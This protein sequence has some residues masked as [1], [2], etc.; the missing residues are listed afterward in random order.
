MTQEQ[1]D[2]FMHYSNLNIQATWQNIEATR[3]AIKYSE[4]KDLPKMAQAMRQQRESSEKA[5]M[6]L[7]EM[8]KCK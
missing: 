6:Y 5:E 8:K 1:H 4:E 2:L 3:L 7:E